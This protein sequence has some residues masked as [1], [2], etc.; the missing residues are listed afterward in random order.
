M[1]VSFVIQSADL[2]KLQELGSRA[3]GHSFHGG[4]KL[5]SYRQYPRQ[6][7][8]L[9]LCIDVQLSAQ[10]VPV[11]RQDLAGLIPLTA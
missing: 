10:A 6:E 8:A 5:V 7:P 4:H 11:S 1:Q 9:H 2:S 3:P